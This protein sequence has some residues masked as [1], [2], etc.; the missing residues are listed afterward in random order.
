MSQ[1]YQAYEIA[2]CK[3]EDSANECEVEYVSS[4]S[5]DNRDSSDDEM[6][7]EFVEY[8]DDATILNEE[9]L[10]NVLNNASVLNDDTDYD[11]GL[12]GKRKAIGAGAQRCRASA[13][14]QRREK[15]GS[16]ERC[17]KCD[18]PVCADEAPDASIDADGKLKK[19][20][21]FCTK[22]NSKKC[23][24]LAKARLAGNICDICVRPKSRKGML[25]HCL[26]S[27]SKGV[28]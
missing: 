13:I 2:K 27:G 1:F 6:G 26:K 11:R 18:Y 4:N 22:E 14:R 25:G 9:S 8:E 7:K 10:F 5:G 12:K 16:G 19:G 17:A 20:R 21:L 24:R 15:R 23:E 3:G 28:R